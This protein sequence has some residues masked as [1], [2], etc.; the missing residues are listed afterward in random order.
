MVPPSVCSI[1]KAFNS[2][3]VVNLYRAMDP[4]SKPARESSVDKENVRRAEFFALPFCGYP[5][6]LL[7]V[8]GT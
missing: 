6:A 2:A 5:Y 3:A 8:G 1:D 4:G 7:I